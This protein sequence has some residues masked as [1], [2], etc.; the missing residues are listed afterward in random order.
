[1]NK[2]NPQDVIKQRDIF[3][4]NMLSNEQLYC[5]QGTIKCHLFTNRNSDTSNI[6]SL[7]L[8]CTK[9]LNLAIKQL[10]CVRYLHREHTD[11]AG[12]Y[13]DINNVRY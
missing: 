10:T 5:R 6:L 9:Q 7:I 11:I 12:H 3:R 8:V 2:N 1:M 13:R 4:T